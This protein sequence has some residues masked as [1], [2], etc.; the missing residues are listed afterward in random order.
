MTLPMI[1]IHS[2]RHFQWE[3]LYY[4]VEDAETAAFSFFCR[5]F[6]AR[7]EERSV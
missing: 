7:L 3:G 4:S 2:I 5:D 1:T 6:E